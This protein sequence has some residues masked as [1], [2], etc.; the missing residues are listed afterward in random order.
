MTLTTHSIIAATITKPIASAHPALI[1]LAAVASHYLSDAIPHWDYKILSVENKE[2]PHG[3][4]LSSDRSLIIKDLVRFGLDTSVGF[5]AALILIGPE[6]PQ[7]LLWAMLAPFGGMLPDFLLGVY[8]VKK[9]S[10]LKPIQL[11]HDFWHTKILLGPYPLIGIPFQLVII[12]LRIYT[13]L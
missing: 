1:F 8:A 5:G 2:D 6:T 13:F 4:R 10:F 7:E 9:F 12:L 3:R 11:F